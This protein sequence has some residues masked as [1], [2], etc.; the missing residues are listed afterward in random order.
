MYLFIEIFCLIFLSA[1]QLRYPKI[2]HKIYTTIF[3]KWFW[4]ENWIMKL[5]PSWMF[6]SFKY[7]LEWPYYRDF[8]V[9]I[10]FNWASSTEFCI[11]LFSFLIQKNNTIE[12]LRQLE[13]IIVYLKIKLIIIIHFQTKYSDRSSRNR[14][15]SQTRAYHESED[16][17]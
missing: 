10:L 13:T 7:N 17:L 4:R 11:I 16:Q 1:C 14:R 8:G 2:I 9:V 15:S 12:F 3:T 6:R 5:K